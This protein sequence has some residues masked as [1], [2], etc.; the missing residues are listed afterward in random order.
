MNMNGALETFAVIATSII[1]VAI[2]TV[3]VKN[4]SNTGS[5]LSSLGSSFSGV[6]VTAMGGGGASGGGGGGGGNPN[7]AGGVNVAYIPVGL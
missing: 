2:I 6:L 4:G 1:G 7:A 3:L 5:V